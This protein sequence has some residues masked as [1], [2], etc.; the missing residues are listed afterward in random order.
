MTR[1]R[2]VPP[3]PS[4]DT[5]SRRRVLKAA[6]GLG[7]A[8]PLIRLG[9]LASEALAESDPK[10]TRPQPGD[11]LVLDQEEL[12]LTVSFRESR[13]TEKKGRAARQKVAA[14]VAG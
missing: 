9:D 13:R 7:V 2:P 4:A 8:L 3:A 14:H 10:T 11:R 1:V 6:A 5:A 12:C